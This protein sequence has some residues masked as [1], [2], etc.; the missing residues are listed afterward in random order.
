M[1]IL[2]NYRLS[3]S[4][5]LLFLGGI[6]FAQTNPNMTDQQGQTVAW[7]SVKSNWLPSLVRDGAYDRTPHVNKVLHWAEPREAD[8]MYRKRIWREIDI[9]QKQN[10][11]FRF[12]GDEYSGGG[13]FIEILTDAVKKGKIKAYSATDD[14]FTTTMTKDQIMEMLQG[15]PETLQVPNPDN[16][17]EMMIKIINNDFNPDLITRFRLKEDWFFDRNLGRMVVRIIGIAPLLD[18]YNEE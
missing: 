8:V 9:R 16:P 14:R 17:D 10:M 15:K 2:S 3:A 5:L 11:P 18:K 6:S 1:R 12:K 7:D 13:M 4:A